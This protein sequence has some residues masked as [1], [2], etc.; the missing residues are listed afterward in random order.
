MAHMVLRGNDP[1]QYIA[2]GISLGPGIA[3]GSRGFTYK[4]Q[5]P[6]T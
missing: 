4:M 2:V 6:K 1:I 5:N 3:R